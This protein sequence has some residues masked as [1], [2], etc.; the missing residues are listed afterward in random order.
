MPDVSPTKWHRAHVTWFFETFVLAD[1]RARVRAVPGHLLVSLQQLLR[2]GRTALRPRRAGCHQPA[3]RPRR[4]RLPRQ[5]RRPDARPPRPAGRGLADQDRRHHRAGLP[6]RAAAPGAA[7]DGHQAR[8]LA[9]PAP[10]GVRRVPQ[11]RGDARPARLG[12]LS[13]AASSRSVTR[14][15]AS[16]STTSSPATSSTSSPTGS[17]TGSSPTASGWSSWPTAATTA[18]SCGSPTAGPGSRAEG[19][20]APFYWTETDGQW[21][22]HT[23]NG[24]WPVN[25]GLPV[26]PRQLLRGR[27]L[28][29]LGRQAAAQRG[30]VGARRDARP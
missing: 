3:R 10:T 5:R 22:E 30:G 25:P 20:D 29:D 4:R 11:R 24:T 8:P 16:P 18:T 2:G 14:A 21:F 6:P 23:L 26:E 1:Q 19:W 28:R 15:G 17:P 7:A 13:T 9:Q 27:G 12:R